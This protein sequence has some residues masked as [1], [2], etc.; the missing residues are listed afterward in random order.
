MA[1]SNGSSRTSSKHWQALRASAKKQLGYYCCA[2][3]GITPA[4]GARLELD[5]IIPAAEGGSD[6]MANLQWLCARHHA[7]KT[8]AESRRGAQRHA[9]RRRLPQ[10]PHPG[11]S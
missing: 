3:C 2:V 11:L 10:R 1:W 7:I 8:R 9:A 6:E 5:H 4:G